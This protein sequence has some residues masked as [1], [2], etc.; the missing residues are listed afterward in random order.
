MWNLSN[1]AKKKFTKCSLLPI[2]ESD[3]EWE[4]VL[5]EAK[6]EGEDIFARLKE[7]LEEVK[8]ELLHILPSRFLP[9]VESGTLNQP[10]LPKIVREDYLQWVREAH[11]EF[12][13]ILDTAA[14]QTQQSAAFLS[15]PVQD[16]FAEILHD[17]IIERIER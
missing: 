12:E 16:I 7:E 5:R 13:Q 3:E 17:S 10:T 2:H 9:Y 15:T 8:A 1:E 14:S 6:E 11:K 4:F